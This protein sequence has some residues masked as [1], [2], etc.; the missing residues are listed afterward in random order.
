VDGTA[1]RTIIG[2]LA[3]YEPY[4]VED[5][6][7]AD[8]V[9][10]LAAAGEA[11]AAAGTMLAAGETVSGLS[12]FLPLINGTPSGGPVDVVTI[13]LTWCGGLSEAVPVAALTA[14]FGRLLAPHDCTG[15]I[16]LA[17]SVQLALAVSTTVV[18]EK[19]RAALRGWYADIVTQVRPVRE[20]SVS[21]CSGP[22]WGASL[23]PE[24]VASATVRRSR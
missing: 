9:G 11:A 19:V 14:A 13:D 4:W 12:Q 21:V 18:Q 5:P 7:R 6:V 2:A 22:G 8:V 17:A 10:G 3:E 16:A 1:A 23:Q 24:Y 20:G 15:P